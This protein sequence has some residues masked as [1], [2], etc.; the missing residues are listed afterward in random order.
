MSLDAWV[1]VLDV[2]IYALLVLLGI[3]AVAIVI[4]DYMEHHEPND[5]H[6]YPEE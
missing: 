2:V 6:G 1:T 5:D 4:G 3:C